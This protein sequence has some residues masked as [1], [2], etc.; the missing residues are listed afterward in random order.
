MYRWIQKTESDQ[1]R[2]DDV[3]DV[4]SADVDGTVFQK[5]PVVAVEI[6]DG[7][8]CH[9]FILLYTQ[10]VRARLCGVG[11]ACCQVP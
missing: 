3:I 7:V 6:V 9:I 10:Y 5:L 11:E 1:W 2:T 4:S 8:D